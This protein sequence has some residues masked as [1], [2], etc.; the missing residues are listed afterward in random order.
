MKKVDQGIPAYPRP[1]GDWWFGCNKKGSVQS[2]NGRSI[3]FNGKIQLDQ[4]HDDDRGA[5]LLDSGTFSQPLPLSLCFRSNQFQSSLTV[6]LLA[7][8][9]ILLPYYYIQRDRTRY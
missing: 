6:N 8:V 1:A 9:I 2:D 3:D 4:P 5:D 7:D